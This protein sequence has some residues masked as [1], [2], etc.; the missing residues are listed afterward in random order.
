M[1]LV[2]C[3][4]LVLLASL[5]VPLVLPGA[6]AAANAVSLPDRQEVEDA[7]PEGGSMTG[8]D[9]YKRF[10]E[11]RMH[12]AVQHQSVISR[13]PGGGEQ[14]SEFW[15]RWKDFRDDDDNADENGVLAKTL[16]KFQHPFDMRHTGFLMVIK[17]KGKLDQWVYTPESRKVRRV[18]LRDVGVMG[19]DF[20]FADVAYQNLEDADYER[21]QDE[22]LGGVPVYVV[23]ST[24]KPFVKSGYR[25]AITWLEKEHFVPLKAVYKDDKGV[26]RR[27]LAAEYDSI[28]EFDGVWIATRSTMTNLKQNTSTSMHVTRLD[29]NLEISEN[30]F[31][32]FRLKLRR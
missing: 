9:I 7:L 23:Q 24:A 13:D 4:C 26:E 18:K 2:R 19:T 6:A 30:L 11:N 5:L 27:L 25:T 21:L 12:S 17:E 3:H 22:E 14:R 16:I 20:T 1:G 15:V 29:P 8:R 31:S 28:R 10:L 32:V